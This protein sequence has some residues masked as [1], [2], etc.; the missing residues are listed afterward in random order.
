MG[1]RGVLRTQQGHR[2]AFFCPGCNEL[3]AVGIPPNRIAWGF[4]G[5][6]ERPTFSPSV[7]VE[8]V[9]RL[10]DDEHERVMRGETVK[11]VPF[12]CHS[13]VRNGKIEFLGDCT[14]ALAGQTVDLVP[15]D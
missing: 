3:H 6:Y 7:K 15:P 14:H 8:G 11:P 5:D 13:F 9:R 10:T 2:L 12:V 1:L 4:N